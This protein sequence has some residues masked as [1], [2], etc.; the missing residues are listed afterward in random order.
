M[1]PRA[2]IA[3]RVRGED[4]FILATAVIILLL[5]LLLVAAAVAL[6]ASASNTSLRT[7]REQQATEAA[8]TGLRIGAY[9]ANALALDLSGALDNATSFGSLL[10]SQCVVQISTGITLPSNLVGGGWCAPVHEV[11]GGGE[12]FCYWLSPLLNVTLPLNLSSTLS[13]TRTIVASGSAGGVTRWASEN[14]ASTLTGSNL[15]LLSIL[16]IGTSSLSLQLYKP[17]GS[18]YTEVKP[19]SGPTGTATCAF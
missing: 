4:G 17:V 18:S 15:G 16:G 8:Q 6:S 19:S 3:R 10:S 9:Q 13:L 1:T 5:L 14:I 7:E 12:S 11:L 2:V